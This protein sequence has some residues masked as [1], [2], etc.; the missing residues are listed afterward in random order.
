MNYGMHDFVGNAGVALI[1]ATYLLLQ[2]GRLD[3]RGIGYSLSNAIGAALVVVS[4]AVD[5]NLS[6]FIVEAA[7]VLI[8]LYGVARALRAPRITPSP[9]T[10]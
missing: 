3:A 4:L 2:T 5:F 10:P 6:A 7:W 8:S 1:L 9:P